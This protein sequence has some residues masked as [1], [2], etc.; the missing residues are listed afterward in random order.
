MRQRIEKK[1]GTAFIVR[2]FEIGRD[3]PEICEWWRARGWPGVVFDALP[4]NGLIVE[5]TSGVKFAAIFVYFVEGA[6]AWM[7]YLVSNP[8]SPLRMRPKAI[9][10]L[11]GEALAFAKRRGCERVITCLSNENLIN[12]HE[13]HGFRVGDSGMT[14]M[15]CTLE[16]GQV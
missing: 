15:V 14:T 10:F 2:P 9:D 12:M 13:R 1:E 16:G 11:V 5:D 3:F 7:D 4:I 6:W 8:G